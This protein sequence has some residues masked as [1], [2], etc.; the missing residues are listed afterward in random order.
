M[1]VHDTQTLA[2]YRALAAAPIHVGDRLW[3]VIAVSAVAAWGL[4]AG[5]DRRLADFGALVTTAI[6][7]AEQR[8]RLA[9]QAYTDPLTGLANHRAFHERLR[10]EVDRALR[11]GRSLSLVV[12]DVDAFKSVNDGAGHAAGDRVL[13]DVARRLGR[14]ARSGDLLAR[15]GGDE[16]A[17]LLPETTAR[18]AHVAV[19][20]ARE[21]VA[22][23]AVTGGQR[24]TI[25]AGI[26]DSTTAATRTGSS[27][28][29]TARC[30][31]R[32]SAAATPR[33][34]TTP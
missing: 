20:R 3:G 10:G 32:R 19:E 1:F 4:P 6:V 21:A 14:V 34:S 29:P 13:A 11:H 2:P 23:A 15:I 31:G 25:S 17:W 33:T 16:F 28:W 9:A 8:E 12:I 18:E 24:V 27:A 26:C 30:T 22:A 7:N 5:A